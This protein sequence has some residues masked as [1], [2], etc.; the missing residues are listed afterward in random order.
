MYSLCQNT[1]ATPGLGSILRAPIRNGR[2]SSSRP[3]R[4]PGSCLTLFPRTRQVAAAGPRP[5]SG[6]RGQGLRQPEVQC[7]AARAHGTSDQQPPTRAPCRPAGS[8]ISTSLRPGAARRSTVMTI[9]L[10]Q[11]ERAIY[12][13][14]TDGRL[15]VKRAVSCGVGE[16]GDAPLRANLPAE[17]QCPLLELAASSPPG[18]QKR[19]G[20]DNGARSASGKLL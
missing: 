13:V 1:N 3:G 6:N 18:H 15:I 14:H 20:A 19:I 7:A 12:V 17:T 5:L 4:G 10:S 16:L 9:C 2:V 8:S 11:R